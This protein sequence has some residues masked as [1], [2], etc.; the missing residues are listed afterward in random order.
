[1]D[2]VC[3]FDPLSSF[4]KGKISG[5]IEFHQCS[6]DH[7]TYINIK[8][9]GLPPNTIRGIHIHEAG[10]L[11]DGCKSA[12]QHYNPYNQMHG[13]ISLYKNE[14]HCGDMC[15]NIVSDSNGMVNFSY[16]DDLISLF[17]PH[18]VIG[19]SVVIHD[20]QDDL[21][22]YRDED[23]ELGKG[24]RTTGNAGDRIACSVIGISKND[25]HPI[26]YHL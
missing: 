17:G 12:C 26:S 9:K 22:R 21:G 23:S 7:K 6:I 19:R 15:S 10:D 3:V 4:N 2:A 16:D 25:Y 8:L 24:S 13:S 20:K 11:T 1:M 5:N 14:R 18:S